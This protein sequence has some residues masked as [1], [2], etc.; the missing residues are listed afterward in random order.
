VT[1]RGVTAPDLPRSI[2]VDD[3]NITRIRLI[4]DPEIAEGELHLVLHLTRSGISVTELEQ[5]GPHLVVLLE[6]IE[7][8]GGR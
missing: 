6:P 7:S 3:P 5:V 2:E 8:P 4:H 1:I